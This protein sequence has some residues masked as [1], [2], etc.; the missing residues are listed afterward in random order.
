MRDKSKVRMLRSGNEESNGERKR[1]AEWN[2][3]NR[4]YEGNKSNTT[5]SLNYDS[6]LITVYWSTPERD[7][8]RNKKVICV[9]SEG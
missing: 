7:N 9:Y 3:H 2:F 5:G 4:R 6:V 1:E 8:F